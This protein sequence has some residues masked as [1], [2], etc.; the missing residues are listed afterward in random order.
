M[1]QRGILFRM[2][3]WTIPRYG[4]PYTLT[5]SI[6]GLSQ[7]LSSTL[8]RPSLSEQLY[9][10]MCVNRGTAEPNSILCAS[11]TNPMLHTSVINDI[12]VLCSASLVCSYSSTNVG[13]P[14]NAVPRIHTPPLS[15]EMGP[16][17]GS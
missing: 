3:T 5:M 4:S 12:N 2:S 6:G 16:C 13:D 11:F 1:M 7:R 14:N 17:D 9:L 10:M 8:S 15:D